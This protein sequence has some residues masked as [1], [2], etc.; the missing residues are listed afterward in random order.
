MTVKREDLVAA[1]HAGVL[2]YSEVDSLLVFLTMRD[3]TTRKQGDRRAR[4][5]RKRAWLMY[6]FAGILAIALATGLGMMFV[7]PGVATLGV[8]TALWFT[9][10]YAVV[11]MGSA[12]WL[13]IRAGGVIR[14]M[15]SVFLV[16]LMPLAIIAAQQMMRVVL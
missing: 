1:A 15:F 3:V 11:A 7:S 10:L 4:P 16:A 5:G 9:V 14:G 8:F 12:A 13:G 2:Q 6:Y